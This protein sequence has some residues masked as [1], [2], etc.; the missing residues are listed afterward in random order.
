M[1]LGMTGATLAVLVACASVQSHADRER[2]KGT[3]LDGDGKVTLE[4]ANKAELARVF[5]NIDYNGDK[6]VSFNE[7]KDIGPDFTRKQF[8][9]YDRNGDG[10]VS[11]DE[12][13]RVQ[14]SK[15]GMKSRFEATDTNKDGFVTLKE[16]DARVKFLQT[17][18]G[19]DW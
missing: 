11:Y 8:S 16:A 12:F 7:A 19:G 15:G 1:M 10:K 6:F 14:V 13:Y 3:D 18:A 2:F 4:E 9:E 17:E 5:K